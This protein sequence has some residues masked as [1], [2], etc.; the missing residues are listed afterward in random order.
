MN[1]CHDGGLVGRL[2]PVFSKN[3]RRRCDV[4][5]LF[6]GI[7]VSKDSSSARGLGPEGQSCFSLSFPMDSSGFADLLKSIGSHCVDL[8]EVMVAMESTGC[9][10]LNL[11]AFLISQGMKTVVIN[12]LIIS[13]FAKL[14]L[15]KTKTD[16]KDALT[17]AQFVL[18]HKEAISQIALSQDVQD[19]RDLARERE[20]LTVLIAS[21]KNDIK[22][23]LQRTFPE[24]ESICDVFSETMLRFLREFPSARLIKTANPRKI[25]KALWYADKRKRVSVSAGEIIKAATESVASLSG[26]KEFILP[27]KISI[28]F[29][30][31]EKQENITKALVKLCKSTMIEDFE[32]ITSIKGISDKTGATFLAE[33]GKFNDFDS[34]KKIIAFAGIDPTIHQ[35]GKFEGMSKISKRGNRHLRRVIFL[36]AKHVSRE[37]TFFKR[38]YLRRR[39]EGLSFK[40]AVLATAHKLIRV[41]FAML[42]NRTYFCA[43]EN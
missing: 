27:E 23:I 1:P 40:E 16:K 28:L 25:A 24:L 8:S 29:H 12:P 30:L 17:I 6:V 10:H 31:I 5:K 41:I 38:Y 36:M 32:I 20:S 39:M 9:Y 26:A 13:N 43:K 21:I 11:Y 3:I 14:S 42:S 2:S 4:Y 15:R 37:D 34:P 19:L 18:M 7:D 22:R 35:S 33:I